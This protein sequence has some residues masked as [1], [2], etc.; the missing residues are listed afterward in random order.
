[1]TVEQMRRKRQQFG[2]SCE[3]LSEL[4]GVSLETVQKIFHDNEEVFS[5]DILK[6][7]ESVFENKR[8]SDR[9]F[10]YVCESKME[11]GI[12]KKSREC[13]LEDY[14]QLPDER[15]AELIDGVIY[16]MSAPTIIHQKISLEI[17]VRLHA[18]ISQKKGACMVFSAPVDVQLDCDNKTMV[19][20]DVGI[21]CDTSKIKRFGIYGA[22]DFVLEVISPS[23]K[24]R[25]YALKL[26][27]YMEAGVREYWIVDFVQAKILV[28]YFEGDNY[29][30]I[31]GF[32]KPVPV[33]IYGGDL[34]IDFSNIAK[35]LEEG[36]E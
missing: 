3:Q 25:D 21:I 9:G 16:D 11:Y 20:P 8:D 34:T 14:Y 12:S 23:T 24:K 31:Y 22:P 7:I 30:V 1:M 6:Q 29:P 15:R 32:D 13:T 18:F 10:S 36:M 35:W 19:E 4:S 26:S 27:K 33:N 28:Y 17:S 2:Y 5:P